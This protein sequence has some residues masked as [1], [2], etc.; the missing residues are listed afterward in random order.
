[1][2]VWPGLAAVAAPIPNVDGEP[3][4]RGVD[5]PVRGRGHGDSS[6]PIYS[7][8]CDVCLKKLL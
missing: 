1:V 2:R 5:D 6:I 3:T 8:P 4:V 7:S